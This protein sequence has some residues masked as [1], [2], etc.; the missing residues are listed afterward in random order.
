MIKHCFYL[1]LE[2]RP[3]R[4]LFI[5]EQLN[6]SVLLKDIY[7]RFD[8][9][10]GYKVHPR[11]V[12]EG[13]LTENAIEDVL[14]DTVTAWGLSLTQGGLGVLLT[15]KKVFE[16][17]SQLDSPAITF[18]DDTRIKDNFDYYLEKV[19]N[20]LPD[21]FDLCY[22]GYGEIK[23]ETEK[24]SDHLS[25][26]KGI[27]TCLPSLIIS[28][29]GAKN[30][31][32]ILKNVD[33]QIDTAI[34]T[35]GKHLNLFVSNEKIVEVKNEFK[36]DIQGNHGC[37][38]DYVKQNY[39][40]STIAVGDDANKKALK[41]CYD[42]NYFKQEL[43]IVTDRKDLFEKVPNVI[44]VEYPNKRFSYNDKIIC[45]EEGFK[46]Y[47]CVVYIDSDSRIFYKNYKNCYTNFL[48]KIEP[49][50]HPSWDWGKVIRD[51]GGFFNSTDISGRIKG[52]GELALL[53]S[54]ELEIPLENAYHYQ[55]G[56][57]IICKDGGKEKILLDTWRSLSSVL[58]D[59]EIYNNVKRVGIGEGN[60]VG[61]SVAKSEIKINSHNVANFIGDNLKYNFCSGG[62]IGDYIK[63]FPD[64][65]TVKISDGTLIKTNE[66]NVEFDNK[67]IDLTYE[68][69]QLSDNLMCLTYKW[70]N[71][72]NVEFLDHEF[73]INNNVY[74]F[75]SEKTGEMVFEYRKNIEIYHTY[76]W[77][78]RRNW[79]EIDRI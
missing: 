14:M 5:E 27:V 35:K 42:L 18:E 21:D 73:K 30:L 10:D 46:Y 37:R 39:I 43:L 4:K 7:E 1:N 55:E 29:K 57:L 13:L 8:S 17:I 41:L 62:Q 9:V 52:Y 44:L 51:S 45:F 63:N 54:K 66:I 36:T 59:Y 77:Y 64:R 58:D 53:K 15:Y 33:N 38:K 31:L 23:I 6:K 2:R 79:K 26:P 60:L 67:F 48:R 69:Y 72:N 19:L 40:I 24:Y 65:T 50:F 75:N 47:D 22:L 76:D 12:K 3:D 70:N 61:L 25:K 20:E 71:K 78:G 56:A 49:G 11:D 68:I 34:Y 28:P 74:H 32:E 16:K